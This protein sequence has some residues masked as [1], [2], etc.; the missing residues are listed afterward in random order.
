VLHIT[1][2]QPAEQRGQAGLQRGRLLA[3]QTLEEPPH[4]HLLRSTQGLGV[5]REACHGCANGLGFVGLEWVAEQ[6]RGDL[7]GQFEQTLAHLRRAG[8]CEMDVGDGLVPA[9]G[10]LAATAVQDLQEL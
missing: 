10:D 2:R 9:I 1:G 8:R 4:Q 5:G 3:G 7:L 6:K